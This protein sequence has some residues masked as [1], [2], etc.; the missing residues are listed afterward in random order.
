MYLIASTIKQEFAYH[1]LLL[2]LQKNQNYSDFISFTFDVKIFR[3]IFSS[4]LRVWLL[5]ISS[6]LDTQKILFILLYIIRRNLGNSYTYK[7]VLHIGPE[8][9]FGNFIY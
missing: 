1:N 5:S 4:L 3:I 8:V 6:F 2:K 7:P 9:L